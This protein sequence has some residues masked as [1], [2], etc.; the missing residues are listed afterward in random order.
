[1]GILD[2]FKKV[3]PGGPDKEPTVQRVHGGYLQ[4]RN[5]RRAEG[6]P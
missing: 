4:L 1:M 5:G 2:M 6:Y 3:I